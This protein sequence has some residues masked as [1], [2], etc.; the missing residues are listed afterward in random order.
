VSGQIDSSKLEKLGSHE[1][2]VFEQRTRRSQELAQ[3]AKKVMPSGV[4]MSWMQGLYRHSPLW[5]LRGD[6]AYF[7]DVD[8]NRYLD[9]NQAD[10][11]G[12][13]GF[14]PAPVVDVIA[15]RSPQGTSFLLPTEDSI[16]TAEMLAQRVGLPAWQFT[17]SA[18]GAVNEVIRLSRVVT[19]RE[20]ILMFEGKYHGHVDDTLVENKSFSGEIPPT[21]VSPKSFVNAA[22][23]P[24]NDIASL[25]KA[26]QTRK[27]ACLIAEPMLTN[28]NLVFPG[29]GFWGAVEEMCRETETLLVLDE[30]HTFT[31]AYG[32]LTREWSIHPD[33]VI[34]GKGFGSGIPFGAYGVSADLGKILEE[35]LDID[36]GPRGVATGG[37][38]Y[39]NSLSMAVAK[40]VLEKCLIPSEYE[41]VQNLG[42]RLGE[43]LTALFKRKGLDWNAPSIGGRA[44]W[45]L[46]PNLPRNA[47]QSL[48]L[49][50][51]SLTDTRRLFMANRGVWEAI[52]TAGPACSFAHTDSDVDKYL[53]VAEDFLEAVS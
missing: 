36:V 19:K 37:T 24:F 43:G 26:L 17:L 25:R 22:L 41:K 39:A 30:A 2:R 51:I 28:C 29:N 4:P 7:E 53:E 1:S 27:F 14:A 44:A 35:K 46:S 13:L 16:L 5:I 50:Q 42:K 12:A 15:Q 49:A 52:S 18:S 20:R 8:G 9:M 11:S 3:R 32:G 48:T 34:L 10:L 6:G 23:V 47:H 40:T 38:L 33:V 21:G 45:V 31:F